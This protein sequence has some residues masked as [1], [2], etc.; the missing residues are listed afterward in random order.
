MDDKELKRLMGKAEKELS[1]YEAGDIPMLR[2]I[3]YSL[4][5]LAEAIRSK[6]FGEG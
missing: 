2:G 6:T 4:L 3:G 5:A 1:K